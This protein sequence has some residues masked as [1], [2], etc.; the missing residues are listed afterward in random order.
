MLQ[1]PQ[2]LVME[3][4]S[5]SKPL[6]ALIMTPTRELALQIKNHPKQAAKHS[7][8]EV[9]L[10]TQI[11]N[12]EVT[13]TVRFYFPIV[14]NSIITL[15]LLAQ[16]N[17][18]LVSLQYFFF[19]WSRRQTYLLFGKYFFFQQRFFGKHDFVASLGL[20]NLNDNQS[21]L[22]TYLFTQT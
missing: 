8:L 12:L 14:R 4:P 13:S 21:A 16:V 10:C 11:D 9:T 22:K 18:C 19:Q 3:H 5:S 2:K 20:G 6:L 15:F 1:K 17:F 7:S